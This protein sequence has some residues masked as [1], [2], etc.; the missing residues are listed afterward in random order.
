MEYFL[1]LPYVVDLGFTILLLYGANQL[2][3]GIFGK[4]LKITIEYKVGGQIG[5]F[6]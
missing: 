4:R 6:K 2:V 5:L 3:W 1:L